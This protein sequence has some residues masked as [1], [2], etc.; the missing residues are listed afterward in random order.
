MED[1]DIK[2]EDIAMNILAC[3]LKK[4][5]ESGIKA[6]LKTTWHPIQLSLSWSRKD[7]HKRRT[8]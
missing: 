7:G 8:T 5:L 2:H 4:M 3:R 6:Y 1:N